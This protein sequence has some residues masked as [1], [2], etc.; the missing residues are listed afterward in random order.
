MT[1]LYVAKKAILHLS[2][3]DINEL[4]LWL[5]Q[6]YGESQDSPSNMQTKQQSIGI[7]KA[8]NNDRQPT[9]FNQWKDFHVKVLSRW[10]N[11]LE[12]LEGFTHFSSSI[13]RVYLRHS[14]DS[15]GGAPQ[16]RVPDPQERARNLLT[17]L[18]D[19]HMKS[20]SIAG[21]VVATLRS[22]YPNAAYIHCRTML[23]SLIVSRFLVKY[24][25]EDAGERY[26][27][28]IA[29]SLDDKNHST[30]IARIYEEYLSYFPDSEKHGWASGIDG[31]TRWTTRAMSEAVELENSYTGIYKSESKFSH[32]DA[33]GFFGDV[34]EKVRLPIDIAVSDVNPSTLYG[35]TDGVSI[36]LVAW[37]TAQNL[38]AT[39]LNLLNAWPIEM[40]DRILSEYQDRCKTVLEVLYEA[41]LNSDMVKKTN[42]GS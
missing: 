42:E 17:A 11:E 25:D 2:R 12:H 10:G 3:A 28:S 39:T 35:Q 32:P 21:A 7:A 14:L 15:M 36:P 34:D 27:G 29:L 31:K 37:E 26:I 22:G 38:A 5:V 16:E 19:L 24:N 6:M 8:I 41:S 9:P 1:S 33:S 18:I 20:C 40:S 4:I 13:G 30:E 23:E